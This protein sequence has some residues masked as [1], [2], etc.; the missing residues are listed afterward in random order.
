MG[1]AVLEQMLAFERSAGRLEVMLGR[2]PVAVETEGDEIR[3]VTLRNLDTQDDE[4]VCFDYV[5]DA[6]ELGDL[7]A[8]AGME[9][10]S[11]AESQDQTGEPHAV[12]GSPQPDNVQS[13]TWC[14][15]LAFDP[16]GSHVIDKPEQYERWRNYV[17]DLKPAWSGH[18]FSWTH[19]RVP[20]LR[21]WTRRLFGHETDD[22][23]AALWNYRRI[24]YRGHY[25]ESM[26][27][28]EVS[29]VNWPQ[30]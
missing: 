2:K 20:H 13:L 16:E 12:S 17:P 6:T 22:P 9:Y 25:P 23:A 10:V 28:H 26:A 8:L 24:H 19:P 5:I 18:L 4:V 29:L 11:G 27:A 15:P 14:F 1:V 30:K 21:P 7:L 3:A